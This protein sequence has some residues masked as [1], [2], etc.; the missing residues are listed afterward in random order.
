MNVGEG[1]E[2][3]DEKGEYCDDS[4]DGDRHGDG[5]LHPSGRWNPLAAQPALSDFFKS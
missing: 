3:H 2:I 5:D 1:R 4:E